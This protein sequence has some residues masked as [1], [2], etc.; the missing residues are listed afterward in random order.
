M[1]LGGDE[2]AVPRVL[3]EL[4]EL[5]FIADDVDPQDLPAEPGFAAP[6][7]VAMEPEPTVVAVAPDL[8]QKLQRPELQ[9]FLQVFARTQ[10]PPADESTTDSAATATSSS[11]PVSARCS[12]SRSRR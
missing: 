1:R 9:R 6:P 5:P 11:D 4:D 7:Q 2:E 12:Q 8:P 3:D 10:T